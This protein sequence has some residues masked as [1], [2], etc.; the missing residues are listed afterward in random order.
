MPNLSISAKKSVVRRILPHLLSR[1]VMTLAENGVLDDDN[2][3]DDDNDSE[4]EIGVVPVDGEYR[5]NQCLFDISDLQFHDTFRMT[6]ASFIMLEA[7]MAEHTLLVDNRHGTSLRLMLMVFLWI[8]AFNETQ[9][10][11]SRMFA[12]ST[13]IVSYVFNEVL[14]A[15]QVLYVDFVK[16]RNA[17]DV[18]DEIANSTRWWPYFKDCIGAIDGTLVHLHVPASTAK[19]WRCRKGFTAQNV[20]VVVNL[21]GTFAYVLAGA[22]GSMH[23]RR[24][25]RIAEDEGLVVPAGKYLLADAGYSNERGYM[26]PYTNTRYHLREWAAGCQAPSH[27][28]ELFNL[29]HSF[30]RTTVERVFRVLKRKWKIIRSTASEYSIGDQVMLMYAL[31]GIHNFLARVNCQW[32]DDNLE[33]EEGEGGQT[34][35]LVTGSYNQ[36]EDQGNGTGRLFDLMQNEATTEDMVVLRDQIAR[37]M[38]A[39]YNGGDGAEELAEIEALI[40]AASDDYDGDDD[41]E[42]VEE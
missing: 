6:K 37:R 31:C 11:A 34:Q 12:L 7:W 32:Q 40:A 24:V 15:I 17:N 27:F 10:N 5:T 28:W 16:P 3:D 42:D 35:A 39:D 2:D 38:W 18:P 36:P 1:V 25:L 26:S 33:Q 19:I 30:L 13:S 8:C 22:E 41:R 23:D 20:C 9:R 21:D 4:V 29:R 14:K